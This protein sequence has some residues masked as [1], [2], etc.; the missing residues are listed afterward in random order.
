[1][2]FRGTSSVWVGALFIS[3]LAACG[4]GG[5]GGEAPVNAVVPPP[6]VTSP[7][8]TTASFPLAAG[9]KARI[10]AGVSDSFDISQGCTGTATITLAPATSAPF[11]GTTAIASQQTF[12]ASV[13][14]CPITSGTSTGTTYY[15]AQYAN[16]GFAISSGEY[17]S[18]QATPTPLP[19]TVQINSSGS[20]VTLNTYSSSAKTTLNGTRVIRWQIEADGTSTTSAIFNLITENYNAS[21]L[22]LSLQQSR[23]RIAQTTG[24]LTIT[25]IDVQFSGTSVLR[26]L[27]TKR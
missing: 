15:N 7:P 22:L 27:Y 24:A 23:Y 13:S 8:P 3:L 4:G 26:L 11:E 25:T 20:I 19:S 10:D 21:N 1:M 6:P 18:F 17:S 14:G 12:T 9:F 5:G 2:N 16:L